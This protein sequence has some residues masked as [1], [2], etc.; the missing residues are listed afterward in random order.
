MPDTFRRL[1]VGYLQSWEVM[2][3]KYFILYLSRIFM[4]LYFT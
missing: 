1:Y 2:K 4:Y 3:Y